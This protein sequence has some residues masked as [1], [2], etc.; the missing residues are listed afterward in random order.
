MMLDADKKYVNTEDKNDIVTISEI[1]NRYIQIN[2]TVDGFENYVNSGFEDPDRGIK[3]YKEITPVEAVK[4]YVE[5]IFSDWEK[6]PRADT[7]K[8]V[9]K[10][11]YG[12]N[13][14]YLLL[15]LFHSEDDGDTEWHLNFF[16]ID[17]K[18][19]VIECHSVNV[20]RLADSH[21]VMFD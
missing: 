5:D 18:D 13:G 12:I 6:I 3:E 17:G 15:N 8:K 20:T 11:V 21:L 1:L 7:S 4:L 16:E 10:L 14:E 9:Y 19:D 2:E